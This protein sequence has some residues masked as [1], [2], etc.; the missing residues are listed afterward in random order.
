MNTTRNLRAA[1]VR[2]WSLRLYRAR[3]EAASAD[4]STLKTIQHGL[5][6]LRV[7][8]CT[9]DRE[10]LLAKV[11]TMLARGNNH[12]ISED[13]LFA[14]FARIFSLDADAVLIFAFCCLAHSNEP[15]GAAARDEKRYPSNRS[16]ITQ[17][18]HDALGLP[19]DRVRRCLRQKGPLL[20]SQ[21]LLMYYGNHGGAL[22]CIE[23]GEGIQ[24]MLADDAC[25]ASLYL[26]RLF[27]AVGSSRLAWSDYAHV[28]ADAERVRACLDAARRDGQGANILVYGPPGTG[29]SQFARAV[30]DRLGSVLYAVR[31]ADTDG[32]PIEGHARLMAYE[33]AQRALAA[34]PHALLL[35]DEI[36][37]VFRGAG[38]SRVLSYKSWINRR[39]ESARVPCLWIGNGLGSMDDSQLRRFDVIMELTPPPRSIRRTL[40][41]R[42]LARWDI[43]PELVEDIA[44]NETFAPAHYERAIRTLDRMGCID[45][46]VAEGLLR[47][48]FNDILRVR[49]LRPIG[50]GTRSSTFDLS[51]LRIDQPIAPLLEL[52]RRRP[53]GRFCLYGPPGTGKTAL[54][55]HIA[56]C[57]DRP[58]MKHRASDLLGAYVGETEQA[59]ARMFRE[60]EQEG[61]VLCLDEADSFLRERRGATQRWEVSQVNELLVR[62]EEFDGVFIASTNLMDCLDAAALRRFDFKLRFDWLDLPQRRQLLA[63]YVKRFG[64]LAD[65]GEDERTREL[66]TLDSLAPGDFAALSRRLE[67]QAGCSERDLLHWLRGEQALKP[68]FA[69]RRIGFVT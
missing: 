8:K 3:L 1:W 22:D 41:Q 56:E 47:D 4:D 36:E 7:R 37:D 55:G 52:L 49:G 19:H 20:S 39:L 54:A 14:D 15:L 50:Q 16:G 10:A 13:P 12:R 51:W 17:L 66:A 33:A 40:L 9:D 34:N 31:T 43:A 21:L 32:D 35:F 27:E 62:L 25:N 26:E 65:M 46:V 24:A 64:L 44:S 28:A 29:K 42:Q 23:T 68:G 38:H 11:M 2:L 5:R 60:A 69:S 57:I 67:A 63:H 6:R 58:L 30:A 59:I 18:L 61:A 45:G 53:S 48:S